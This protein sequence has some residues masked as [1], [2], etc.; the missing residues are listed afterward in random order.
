MGAYTGPQGKGA[1]DAR[2]ATKRAEAEARNL[3]TP[4]ERRRYYRRP[5][6]SGKR[7]YATE[8]QARTELVGALVGANSGDGKRHEKRVYECPACGRWH[9]TSKPRTTLR[10]VREP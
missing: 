7:K 3:A 9:L 6:P 1:A 2:R 5:C 10:Q 4:T 8:S